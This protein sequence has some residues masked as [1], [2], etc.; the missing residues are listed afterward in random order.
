MTLSILCPIWVCL[1]VPLSKPMCQNE[2]AF[3][4]LSLPRQP[5]EAASSQ[6]TRLVR[7]GG[8][9]INSLL[10]IFYLNATMQRFYLIQFDPALAKTI[11]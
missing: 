10:S 11:Q 8:K 2:S 3:F 7:V 9:K 6:L 4:S 5:A 1:V